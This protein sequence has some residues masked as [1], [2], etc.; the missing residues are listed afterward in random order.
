MSNPPAPSANESAAKAGPELR[1]APSPRRRLALAATILAFMLWIGF[2]TFLAATT[3]HP[4]VL[5]RPQF[6]VSNLI[7]I[8]HVEG[9]EYP[10]PAVEVLQVVWPSEREAGLKAPTKLTIDNVKLSRG[11]EGPGEYVLALTRQASVTKVTPVPPS[12]GFPANAAQQADRLRIYR[13]TPNIRQQLTEIET[14]FRRQ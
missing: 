7:V 1:P 6:L 9:R 14:Q 8:A 13:D 2:L 5:S 4:V 12:P 11:W 3:S 10:E